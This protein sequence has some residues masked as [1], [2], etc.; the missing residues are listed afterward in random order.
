MSQIRPQSWYLALAMLI[1]ALLLGYSLRAGVIA[2]R[3]PGALVKVTAT[4]L[5]LRS[6]N[7][8]KGHVKRVEDVKESRGVSWFL[9][10]VYSI[11]NPRVA[12][13]LVPGTNQYV[14]SVILDGQD[15]RGLWVSGRKVVVP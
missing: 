3:Y 11:N 12:P 15:V 10:E 1:V 13:P 7:A 8:W 4:G 6:E 5:L 14:R 2:D 9:L